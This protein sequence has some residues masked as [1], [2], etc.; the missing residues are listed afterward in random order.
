MQVRYFND[1][2]FMTMMIHSIYN[3]PFLNDI[4]YDHMPKMSTKSV[5][6]FCPSTLT[7]QMHM[8][9]C[10]SDAYVKCMQM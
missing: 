5:F 7:M 9:S 10:M 8:Q 3:T 1:L 6:L 4:L 2:F